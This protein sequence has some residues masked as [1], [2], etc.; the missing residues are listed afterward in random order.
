[1]NIVTNLG[2]QNSK[3]IAEDFVSRSVFR[4]KVVAA[5]MY[6]RDLHSMFSP[7]E[8]AGNMLEARKCGHQAKI[9]S[10]F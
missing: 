5:F 7:H 3:S 6:H 10:N 1:M 4:R 8:L 2:L 9:Q